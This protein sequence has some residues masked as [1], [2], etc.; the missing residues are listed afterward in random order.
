MQKVWESDLPEAEEA[1]V[2][3]GFDESIAKQYRWPFLS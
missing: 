2:K 3:G 1:R